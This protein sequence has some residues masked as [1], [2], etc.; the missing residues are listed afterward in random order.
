MKFIA[1]IKRA[2]PFFQK[3]FSVCRETAAAAVGYY[4]SQV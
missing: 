4:H 3:A 1:A 2:S